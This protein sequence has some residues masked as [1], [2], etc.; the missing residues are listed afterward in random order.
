M[1]A[2]LHQAIQ[3]A[4]NA[5][6]LEGIGKCEAAVQLRA[7]AEDDRARIP[8]G[9]MADDGRIIAAKS[10]EGMPQVVRDSYC[11]P[12]FREDP[13]GPVNLCWVCTRV[14]REATKEKK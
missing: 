10:K 2:E 4:L 1:I 12:V 6:E 5:M 9:W 3:D 13:A 11:L 14:L 7:A 8:A